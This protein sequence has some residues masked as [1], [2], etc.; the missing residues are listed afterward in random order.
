MRENPPDLFLDYGDE[1][2]NLS[3]GQGR[4][5]WVRRYL[6][7]QLR[8]LNIYFDIGNLHPTGKNF[9]VSWVGQAGFG[10]LNQKPLLA[11]GGLK[12]TGPDGLITGFFAKESFRIHPKLFLGMTPMGAV[13]FLPV[14]QILIRPLNPRKDRNL[15]EISERWQNGN[16]LVTL[17]APNQSINHEIPPIL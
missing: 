4:N 16:Y 14:G 6:S 7:S 10:P 5:A 11:V 13:K 1:F 17:N 9:V 3:F 15:F 2:L 12:V 8:I